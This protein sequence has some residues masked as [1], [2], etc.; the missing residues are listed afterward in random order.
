MAMYRDLIKPVFDISG[1]LIA[2]LVLG[3]ILVLGIL[4]AAISTRGNP[5]F[6]H[7]RPGLHGKIIKIYKLKTMRNEYS[8]S[9]SVTSN[10]NR[11][12]PIGR[13]LRATSID[14]LP[15]LINVLQGKLSL[16]GP[17]PLM[18]W[19]LP[20]YTAEQNRRHNVKPGI[21][22]LA[23]ISGRNALSWER[24]FELD[25][26]YVDEQSLLL[27]LKILCRTALKIFSTAGINSGSEHFT[28]APFVERPTEDHK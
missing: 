19:Y 3:P 12:T 27:D 8:G 17:R 11:V 14:E 21:T 25:G 15:Q 13:F 5:F 26:Q 10:L 16:V 2:L 1:A 28:V 4:L 22:G 9:G 18:T 24:K 20:H 23:Q 7:E 6:V